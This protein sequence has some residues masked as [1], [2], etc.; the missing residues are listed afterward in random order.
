VIADGEEPEFFTPN[1]LEHVYHTHKCLSVTQMLESKTPRIFKI[2][3]RK[4]GKFHYTFFDKKGSPVYINEDQ[5]MNICRTCLG[6]YIKQT[7]TDYHVQTFDLEQFSKHSAF[8]G[9]DTDEMEKGRPFRASYEGRVWDKV[10][11]EVKVA[12]NFTCTSCGFKANNIDSKRFIHVHHT[13]RG[14][15]AHYEDVVQLLCIKCHSDEPGHEHMK[16]WREYQQFEQ[17]LKR[18]NKVS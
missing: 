3:N 9:F 10:S 7:V 12:G 8:F 5:S 4:D 1:S 18:T 6:K 11:R 14:R 15:K 2:N 17:I 13:N 16:Q